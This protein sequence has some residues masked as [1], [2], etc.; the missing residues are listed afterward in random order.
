[1]AV[2]VCAIATRMCARAKI[3]KKWRRL[4]CLLEDLRKECDTPVPK[5]KMIAEAIAVEM[6][7]GLAE[8]GSSMK[9]LPTYVDVLP[10]GMETGNFYGIDFGGTYYRIVRIELG[11]QNSGGIV[12]QEE[13]QL[14]SDYVKQGTCEEVFDFIALELKK[15]VEAE[16]EG[17]SGSIV[18]RR[19][20]GFSFSFPV[21][22]RT[23]SSGNLVKWTKGFAV[24]DGVDKDVAECL[25]QAMD[26]IGLHMRVAA[27]V[28]DTV[29]TF[30]LG[31]YQD[32]D[33]VAAV[34]IGTGTNACYL[35]KVNSIVRLPALLTTSKVMVVNME[36]GN[37]HYVGLPRTL[38]D[39]SLDADSSNP[40]DQR[41]EKMISGMYLGD[42]VRRV[43]LRMLQEF[44]EALIS[45]R[46]ST[47]FTLTSRSVADMNQ[48]ESPNLDQVAAVFRDVFEISEVP[49]K[50]RRIVADVCDTV[51]RRSANLVAAGIVGILKKRWWNVGASETER[52]RRLVVALDGGVY[53]GY[54][55]FREYLQEAVGKIVERDMTPYVVLS[56]ANHGPEVG[57][58]LMA[59][60]RS[61][62][63]SVDT[64]I[65]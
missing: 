3:R 22:Q 15:F 63:C 10:Q 57:A 33:T 61:P 50:F 4:D 49:L 43:V 35:E 23:I 51:C 53:Q 38:Y 17:S 28:N 30:C 26:K 55:K 5:L 36:W 21:K 27:V 60:S 18:K 25:Q 42:I 9:M 45:N 24:E 47:P 8:G 32:Q 56:S 31:H 58:A 65:A 13:K 37:F 64:E 41:F 48:D 12:V 54:S 11:S 20:L 59:A 62:I 40:N 44:D 19:E 6:R 1:M 14:I 46:L 34:V 2:A 52:G 39:G 29:G 16:G 7:A